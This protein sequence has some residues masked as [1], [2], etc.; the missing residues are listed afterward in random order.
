MRAIDRSA[1]TNRWRSLPAG[2]KLA[3]AFGLMLVSLLAAGPWGQVL[4]IFIALGL[5]TVG[6]GV[7][8]SD[9]ARAAAVPLG[10]I[11]SGTL[12]QTVSISLSGLALLPASELAGPVD[13]AL[14][15]LACV[16]ALLFLALT[17]PLASLMMLGRRIGIKGD[18]A[19]IALMMV[20][21]VWVLLDCL[22]QGQRSQAAR[23]GHSSLPRLL[24]SHGLLLASLLPRVLGRAARMN[25]G[26]SARGFDGTLRFLSTDAPASPVHLALI[27]AALSSLALLVAWL[28]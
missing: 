14:R 12:V 20:R 15:S 4:I 3:V 21:I 25:T 10:F 27:A 19:D 8:G 6:A 17:T 7:R 1:Q 9:L 18:I 5:T 23:L 26:L 2:E 16:S 11:L 22:D 28:S 13:V 24:R